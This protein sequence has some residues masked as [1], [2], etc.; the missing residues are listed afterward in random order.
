M[1]FWLDCICPTLS[2]KFCTKHEFIACH[3]GQRPLRIKPLNT[4]KIIGTNMAKYYAH[5]ATLP[6]GASDPNTERWQL[7]SDHLRNVADLA[8]KF[9]APFNLGKE[10]K[11]A[12]LLHDLGKFRDEFQ[13]YLCGDRG[14]SVETQHAI[15]G[16]AWAMERNLASTLPIAGHHAGLHDCGD[17]PGMLAK[18]ALR[19]AQT[20]PELITRL[21]TELGPLPSLPS[22]PSWV[23][24]GTLCRVLHASNLFLP[25]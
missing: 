23:D 11:L 9:A 20:V 21:E 2:D 24:D 3:A 13:A 8:E 16:A 4:A 17:L 18:P 15:F 14:S 12:G 10:A 25:R 5:T 19:I 22:P 7:L 1:I 6:D